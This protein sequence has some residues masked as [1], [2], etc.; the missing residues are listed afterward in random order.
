MDKDVNINI[1]QVNQ[2]GEP[3]LNNE[4]SDG[5]LLPENEA[6]KTLGDFAEQVGARDV[7][8]VEKSVNENVDFE[9][10]SGEIA[11]KVR[12]NVIIE[13]D[14][15]SR[16]DS[17]A[18]EIA[19]YTEGGK[20]DEF[21]G[22]IGITRQQMYIFLTIILVFII[23]V[24]VSFYYLLSLFSN[25]PQDITDTPQ[26]PPVV[27]E[28]PAEDGPGF[29]ERISLWF[30]SLG[31]ENEP[32][33]D[34][35]DE[36]VEDNPVVEDPI[37]EDDIGGVGDVGTIGSEELDDIDGDAIELL[38]IIGVQQRQ[39][40][41]LGEYIKIY[42]DLRNVFNTDLF[43]YLSVVNDR[44]ASFE[45]YLLSLRGNYEKALIAI[46]DLQVE[47]N[48]YNQRLNSL[49][50]DLD[51]IEGQF[52]GE[53][54]ALNA[55]RVDELLVVFQEL[56]RKEVVLTSE[57]R[58]RQAVLDRFNGVETIVA[59]RITAIELNKDAFV[60]GVQVVDYRNI[61]LDLIIENN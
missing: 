3:S 11:S 49:D 30:D 34:P 27:V 40:S 50:D 31:G 52:F 48:E 6:S 29:F 21:L 12:E 57:L 32:V 18:E 1:D 16:V 51:Q 61:D 9:E 24:I 17:A 38:N 47:I 14:A 60:K 4:G 13:E 19:S 35:K 45:S 33:E 2:N 46:N 39:E 36:P 55:S 23:G 10:I 26:E 28:E 15:T 59:D 54:E 5:E 25:A 44:E 42:R 22:D 43:A 53:V 7:G 41:R 20:L 58:A 37:D 8:N 56:G